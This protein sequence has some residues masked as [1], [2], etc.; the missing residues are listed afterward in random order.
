MLLSSALMSQILMAS[1]MIA[2]LIMIAAM[3]VGIPYCKYVFFISR[4]N[5]TEGVE[6]LAK[7]L[8]GRVDMGYEKHTDDVFWKS[9]IPAAEILRE[10]Y[11]V[12]RLDVLEGPQKSFVF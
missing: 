1:F 4:S 3:Y 12:R 9:F 11:Q 8:A 10:D 6:H 7:Y 2:V 5:D